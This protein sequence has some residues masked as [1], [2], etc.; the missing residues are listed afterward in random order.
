MFLRQLLHHALV[1]LQAGRHLRHHGLDL[2]V[3]WLH[4]WLLKGLLKWMMRWLHSRSLGWLELFDLV[5]IDFNK[6][7]VAEKSSSL[8][9]FRFV[10]IFGL[11]LPI[12]GEKPPVVLSS[13]G[14]SV[15]GDLITVT[16]HRR[17]ANQKRW[18]CTSGAM[19]WCTSWAGSTLVV[20]ANIALRG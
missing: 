13:C 17:L 14:S 7:T 10:I 11:R 15:L 8:V 20:G 1:H 3:V 5:W 2:I 9:L 6:P 12:N 4:R 16:E 19:K 18:L